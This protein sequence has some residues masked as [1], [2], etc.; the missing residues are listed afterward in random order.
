[1]SAF[2]ASMPIVRA[3]F[4]SECLSMPTLAIK[5]EF[6]RKSALLVSLWLLA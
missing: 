5:S 6:F 1:M 2:R 4:R 3:C